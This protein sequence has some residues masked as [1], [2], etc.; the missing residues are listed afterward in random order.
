M[1]TAIEMGRPQR[2]LFT[3]PHIFIEH[4]QEWRVEAETV[5]PD[6]PYPLADEILCGI[7][8]HPAEP[9]EV[10]RP[11]DF[12]ITSRVQQDDVERLQLVAN[13]C[14]RCLDF[15][16]GHGLVRRSPSEVEQYPVAVAP[17]QRHLADCAPGSAPGDP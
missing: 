3:G 8:A 10:A 6:N 16:L 5:H 12:A 15:L 11:P 4:P 2:R 7:R 9:L 13:L 1:L 17:L 14:Q